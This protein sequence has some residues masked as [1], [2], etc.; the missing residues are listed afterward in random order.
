MT[1]LERHEM[2]HLMCQWCI[3]IVAQIQINLLDPLRLYK[4]IVFT[5]M[6]S[7]NCEL[8][9]EKSQEVKPGTRSLIQPFDVVI[10]M[11]HLL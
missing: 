3:S 9:G 1:V 4:L 6:T 11:T 2:Q 7:W 10:I 8:D 5:E